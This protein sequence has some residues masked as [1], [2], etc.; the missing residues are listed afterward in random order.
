W[1]IARAWGA[2]RRWARDPCG[3]PPLRETRI[4]EARWRRG[5]TQA[6]RDCREVNATSPRAECT[7]DPCAMRGGEFDSLHEAFLTRNDSRIRHVGAYRFAVQNPGVTILCRGGNAGVS[8][9]P[10]E[11]RPD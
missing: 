8:R 3:G 9:G 10:F 7:G 6:P 4:G 2:C 11:S 1:V 5:R